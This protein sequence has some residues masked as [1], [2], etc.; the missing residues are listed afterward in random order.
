M[1]KLIALDLDGTTLNSQGKLTTVT[2]ET[3]VQAANQG[4][5][6]VIATGRARCSLPEEVADLPGVEYVITSNGAAI[7]ELQRD[8]L[9]YENYIDALA[10]EQVHRVL[11]Q[12][13]FMIEVFIRGRAYVEQHIFENLEKVGLSDSHMSYVRRTRKPHVGVMDMMIRNKNLVENININFTDLQE[14]RHMREKLLKLRDITVT[15]SSQRNIEIGG[16]TTSK[17]SAL[18]ALCER[19][20]I[21]INQMMAC[22]DSHNDEAMLEVAGLAVAMGNAEEAV[23]QRAGYITGTNDQDGVAEAIRKFA[24]GKG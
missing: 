22:G 8:V 20:G 13:K 2:R 19:L 14:R 4:I 11:S 6:V 21:H 16:A 24:L 10:L 17:A 1:I 9:V 23:K 12:E 5:H 15:S 3:L 7:T 18:K